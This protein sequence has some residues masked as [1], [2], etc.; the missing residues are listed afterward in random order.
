MPRPRLNFEAAKAR[1]EEHGELGA[2][3]LAAAIKVASGVLAQAMKAPERDGEVL[4]RKVGRAVF[5]R[6]PGQ[7][8]REH[9]EPAAPPS[10]DDDP[11]EFDACLW[12]TSGDLIV[13]GA[14]TTEDGGILI[15][16]A[17][18]AVI[19]RLIAWMPA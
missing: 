14:D 7:E 3:E 15:T 2:G 13:Y 5:Y 6:L 11:M 18:L 8:P 10:E 1:L 12:G 16:K 19:R 9:T 17:Q 4:K